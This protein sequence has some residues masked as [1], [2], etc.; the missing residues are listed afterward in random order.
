MQLPEITGDFHKEDNCA[1]SPSNGVST[2]MLHFTA[3][4]IF[5]ILGFQSTP[6]A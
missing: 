3:C 1:M 2:I 5:G 6:K 4:T